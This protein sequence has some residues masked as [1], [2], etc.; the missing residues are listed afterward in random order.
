MFLILYIPHALIQHISIYL[1]PIYQNRCDVKS[2]IQI[3]IL[4][5]LCELLNI[6][7]LSINFFIYI[8]GVHHYRSSAI[9]ML[10]LHHFPMFLPYLTIEHRNS[11]GSVAFLSTRRNT[12]TDTSSIKLNK[13]INQQNQSPN[14]TLINKRLSK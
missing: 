10:G 12:P 3:R 2:L 4:K 6:I 7:A 5:R 14:L 8:L 9:Q 1:V 13:V 11:I